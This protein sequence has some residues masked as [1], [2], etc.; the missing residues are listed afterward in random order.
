MNLK[1]LK[2]RL[3]PGDSIILQVTAI[4]ISEK[5]EKAERFV[6]DSQPPI[7]STPPVGQF[8]VTNFYVDAVTKKLVVEYDDTP[9]NENGV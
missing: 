8:K 4:V 9:V 6:I 5:G 2:S 3:K 7:G 1:D